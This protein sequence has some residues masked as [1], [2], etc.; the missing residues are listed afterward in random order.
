MVNASSSNRRGRW[1]A[2]PT[3]GNLP[4]EPAPVGRLGPVVVRLALDNRDLIVDLSDLPCPRLAR[5]I[6]A[7][8]IELV[9]DGRRSF[10]S[11]KASVIAVRR[12]LRIVADARPADI[13]GLEVTDLQGA[14]LDR[15]EHALIATYGAESGRPHSL[16][17]LV[18]GL[19]RVACASMPCSPELLT[20]LQMT[21]RVAPGRVRAPLD[22]YPLPVFEALMTAALADV[23]AVA[24]R[25]QRGEA[26]AARGDDPGLA[27][28]GRVEN[29]L[30][31]VSRH[32]P[33]AATDS[34]GQPLPAVAAAGGARHI[35]GMLYPTAEDIL[36]F[37]IALS[38]LTGLEPECVRGL[39]ADCLTDPARGFVSLHYLKRRAGPAAHKSMRIADGGAVHHPGG[40]IRLAQRVTERARTQ[41]GTERL[42]VA[43]A[44]DGR[45]LFEAFS[46][47]LGAVNEY[48]PRWLYRH[49]LDQLR[50]HDRP[51]RSVDLRRLRKTVKSQ[52]YL[53]S[54]GVLADFV[55]GHSRQ[56]AANHYADIAAHREV[57]EQAVEDGLREA[58]RAG[59]PPIVLSDNGT[60][61]DDG[62]HPLPPHEVSTADLT[63]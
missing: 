51:L 9:S 43:W 27:G 53:R 16:M 29:L 22:A 5:Q 33:L 35:N 42:W 12:F 50:D 14:D 7:A 54:T 61:L 2:L 17:E 47:G 46:A 41:L 32:G 25:I 8:L 45:G 23:R 11:V 26:L 34:R 13:A 38:C 24:Q 30:W 31:H 40:L 52:Q 49:G 4:E 20:R 39:R 1:A 37:V 60:R 10:T 44:R 6:G 55:H 36:A 19:L 58:L 63:G 62:P 57:H 21:T 18:V 3:A 15:F 28:W 56:V 48:V 59:A